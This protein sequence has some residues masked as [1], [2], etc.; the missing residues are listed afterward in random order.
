[1]KTKVFNLGEYRRTLANKYKSADFFKTDNVEA[2]RIR[3]LC[4]TMALEDMC[5]WF[6]GEG[7]IAIYDGTNTTVQRRKW[8]AEACQNNERSIKLF[9]VES[10]CDDPHVVAQNIAD[11][12]VN[13]PDYK[14]MKKEDAVDDFKQRI[15]NYEAHYETLDEIDVDKNNSFIKVYNCGKRF[16]INKISGNIQCKIVYYLTNMHVLPRTIYLSRHGESLM[17]IGKLGMIFDRTHWENGLMLSFAGGGFR[18]YRA[19]NGGIELGKSGSNSETVSQ[20][21]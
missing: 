8:L 2:M 16:L 14:E 21:S 18:S 7:E 1:M 15:K 11:V 5:A 20:N 12:K 6:D 10:V 13:S 3:T 9:F 17:N 4:A 19:F